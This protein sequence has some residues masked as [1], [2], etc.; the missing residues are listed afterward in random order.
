ME[1]GDYEGLSVPTKL[2]YRFM[3]YEQN[4]ES[5]QYKGTLLRRK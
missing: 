1:S 5:F 2:C 4:N 3:S